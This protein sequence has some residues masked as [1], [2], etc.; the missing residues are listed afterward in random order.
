MII[1]SLIYKL[2]NLN[3]TFIIKISKIKC[4]QTN[5]A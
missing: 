1:N 2:I 5:L 3:A 4:N